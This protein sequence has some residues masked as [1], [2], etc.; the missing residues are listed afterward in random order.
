MPVT[1]DL[2]KFR[3]ELGDNDAL[4]RLFTDDEANY[5][6]SA[7]GANILLAV[8]D[9]CEILARRYAREFDFTANG[10]KSFK[11]SQKSEAYLKMA[12]ELR[13][14]AGAGAGISTLTLTKVDGTSSDLSTR[15]G[16]GD[17]DDR[18]RRRYGYYNPDL[19]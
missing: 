9:G 1:T 3:L 4:N 18:G 19:P 12:Q 11:R 17:T 2:E 7:R 14:R 15:D 10:E 8:A 16:A 6:L 13:L 5:L